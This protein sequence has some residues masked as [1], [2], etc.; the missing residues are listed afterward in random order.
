MSKRFDEVKVSRFLSLV[1]RHAPET[2]GLTLDAQGWAKVA[3]L[4]PLLRTRGFSL[5]FAQ[6]E[7]VVANNSKQRF[8]LNADKSQIRANQGHSIHI[9]LGYSSQQPPEFLW[10]G[11]ASRFLDS[12]QQTGLSKQKRQHVHLTASQQTALNVGKRYGKPVLLKIAAQQMYHDG[13]AFYLSDNAVW[14]TEHIPSH[15]LAIHE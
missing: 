13:F 10:H 12:I 11:T 6:L 3:Q 7:Q 15:Y 14:L 2:I 9:D 1:L 8:A 4:L 5:T